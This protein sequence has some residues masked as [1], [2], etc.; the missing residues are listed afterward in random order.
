MLGFD[1]K[2]AR[3]ILLPVKIILTNDGIKVFPSPINAPAICIF[4][5]ILKELYL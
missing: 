4:L 5:K 1:I 2:Y 3:G